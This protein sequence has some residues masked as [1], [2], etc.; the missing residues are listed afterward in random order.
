[1][2]SKHKKM[3]R[4]WGLSLRTC[5]ESCEESGIRP[6]VIA[7]SRRMPKVIK[8]II[9]HQNEI[10]PEGDFD[11]RELLEHCIYTT[12]IALPFLYK[13]LQSS[14]AKVLIINDTIVSG[15]SIK[16]L[17]RILGLINDNIRPQ[18]LPVGQ[19]MYA[20][21]VFGNSEVI[22]SIDSLLSHD[23]LKQWCDQTMEWIK[24]SLPIEVEFPV[25]YMNE[26]AK[27]TPEFA[28]KPSDS[29]FYWE[30]AKGK[31]ASELCTLIFEHPETRM[32]NLDFAKARWF[33][34]G[35]E[36]RLAVCTPFCL[37]QLELR[38]A[39]IF[40]DTG[41]CEHIWKT[42]YATL[43]DIPFFDTF[44]YRSLIIVANYLNSLITCALNENYLLPGNISRHYEIRSED[45]ALLI[46]P[47][48]ATLQASDTTQ[49]RKII[50]S[51]GRLIVANGDSIIGILSDITRKLSD[52]QRA[53]AE[54]QHEV[55]SDIRQETNNDIN[56][57]SGWM[58]FW[59]AVLALLGVI[60][61]AAAQYFSVRSERERMHKLQRE[62][63]RIMQEM[64]SAHKKEIE[65]ME[66]AHQ[67]KLIEY[68]AGYRQAVSEAQRC[69][70]AH[71]IKHAAMSLSRL[72]DMH[73]DVEEQE[74]EKLLIIH[75]HSMTRNLNRLLK[76][77]KDEKENTQADGKTH[78]QN[79][80]RRTSVMTDAEMWEDTQM[81]LYGILVN[82]ESFLRDISLKTTVARRRQI[83]NLLDEIDTLRP[84]LVQT[85]DTET[86][87]TTLLPT[88]KTLNARLHSL[89]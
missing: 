28:Q 80:N 53:I 6:I 46:G 11:L 65:T 24:E 32:F 48:L 60:L 39:E 12:E 52:N 86:F 31:D 81:H 9:A 47:E 44:F 34:S 77:I 21:T 82:L 70:S 16:A 22:V 57:V 18:I 49:L 89:V 55:I 74:E 2:N 76:N 5:I 14:H 56:R 88:F 35:K 84:R 67:Q 54:Q 72:H 71:E 10:W 73:A 27:E 85:P 63:I 59:I 68:E 41:L 61:P 45:L 66:S 50:R 13:R 87:L 43:P 51:N 3:I 19:D 36:P 30:S 37:P 8:W 4:D 20:N 15:N 23:S 83:T 33:F 38:N 1:M 26:L 29:L 40:N 75:L 7:L 64:K 17:V 79:G 25:L 58:G 78:L 69:M 62:Q 42:I